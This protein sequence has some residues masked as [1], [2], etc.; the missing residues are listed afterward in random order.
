MAL[1]TECTIDEIELA[2]ATWFDYRKNII[3]PKVSWGLLTHEADIIVLNRTG[4]LSEVEIKRSWSDFLADFRKSHNHDD[5]KI[6]MRWYCVPYSIL[7][8]CEKKLKEVDPERRWGLLYYN[9]DISGPIREC[10]VGWRYNPSNFYKPEQGKKLTPEQ[11]FQLARLGAMRIWKLKH[12]VADLA[13]NYKSL[14]YKYQ[15]Q[16]QNEV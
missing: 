14:H 2:V 3:V 1:D 7:D 5:S 8:K 11:M 4:Y 10:Y 16:L 13:Y 6:K 9:L 12:K 15:Q